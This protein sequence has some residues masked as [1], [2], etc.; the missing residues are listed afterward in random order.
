MQ[1]GRQLWRIIGIL[2]TVVMT[3]VGVSAASAQTDRP[4]QVATTTYVVKSGD[5]CWSRIAARFAM[6][7]NQL[8]TLNNTTSTMLLVGQRIQVPATE[9]SNTTSTTPT[10]PTTVQTGAVSYVVKSGDCCWSRIATR[11]GVTLAQLLALNNATT[12]TPLI[13]GRSIRVPAGDSVPVTTSSTAPSTTVPGGGG[14]TSSAACIPSGVSSYASTWDPQ[15]RWRV[16]KPNQYQLHVWYPKIGPEGPV[17]MIGGSLSY[18]VA[19]ML[20]R[21]LVAAGYGPVCV[22]ARIGRQMAP[23]STGQGGLN[24]AKRLKA[25]FPSTGVR[26]NVSLGN[27]DIN[28]VSLT[29]AINRIQPILDAIGATTHPVT[30][31]NLAS[32][33][34]AEYRAKEASF[35]A[36]L[37][38]KALAVHDWA[39]IIRANPSLLISDCL[40]VAWSGNTIRSSSLVALFGRT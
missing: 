33:R 31:S 5:C 34:T 21:D 23:L 30:W 19:E 25:A 7:A 9:A 8:M 15:R 20:T 17:V 29:T 35:N 26:W 13:V 10:T 6:T 22:D 11:Y 3:V 16:A 24:I 28:A 14:G 12:A 40:H 4:A 36:A 32:C 39:S 18:G 37:A 38:T 1:H 27:N 2:T